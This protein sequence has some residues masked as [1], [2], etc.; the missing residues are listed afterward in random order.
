MQ[1]KFVIVKHI[2]DNGKFLFFVPDSVDLK[3]GEKI[4]C[5]T[6]RGADQLGI[7]C[8]DSF[9]AETDV[10]CPLFG[11]HEHCMKYV[12]GKV[13]Y[14]RFAEA[15]EGENAENGQQEQREQV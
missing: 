1:K 15:Q 5:D 9:M 13:T 4:V 8:C 7:C 14:I 12:T 3:A 6:S 2:Q 10:V 11:T